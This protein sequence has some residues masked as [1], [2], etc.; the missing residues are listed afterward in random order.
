[1]FS[2]QESRSCAAVG[3]LCSPRNMQALGSTPIPI[4]IHNFLLFNPTTS[5]SFLFVHRPFFVHFLLTQEAGFSS[6][7]ANLCFLI[8]TQT[9]RIRT[10]AAPKGETPKICIRHR[11]KTDSSNYKETHILCGTISAYSLI[12]YSFVTS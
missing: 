5:L 10:H 12:T 7:R 8:K 11:V 3:D 2:R 4:Q 1:M 9:M 6:N